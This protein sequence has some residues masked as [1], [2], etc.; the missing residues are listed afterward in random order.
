[1]VPL[2]IHAPTQDVHVPIKHQARYVPVPEW[3]D[4]D[5]KDQYLREKRWHD[6]KMDQLLAGP[7]DTRITLQT[8]L[9]EWKEAKYLYE[10]DRTDEGRR[11]VFGNIADQLLIARLRAGGTKGR[12]ARENHRVW[13]N[14]RLNALLMLEQE[15][16]PI[17][18]E[19]ASLMT[20]AALSKH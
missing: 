13:H 6:T 19:A 5:W 2:L 7:F 14:K 9:L 8:L 12:Q 18:E 20:P 15:T 16:V 4:Y 17:I 3:K 10:E 1:M 11:V